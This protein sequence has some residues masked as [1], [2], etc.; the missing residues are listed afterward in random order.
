MS[1]PVGPSKV[2][3]RVRVDA[4]FL[5]S[6]GEFRIPTNVWLALTRLN[7]WIEPTLIAEWI[8]LMGRYLGRQGRTVREGTAQDALTWLDPAR[9][10]AE[11]RKIAAG[12]ISAG[13]KIYCIWT[14]R[15]LKEG[16]FDI[17]HCLPFVCWP[18]SDLWNLMPTTMRVNRHD[19]ADRLV[20]AGLF[21]KAH[22]RIL[23]WWNRAYLKRHDGIQIRFKQEARASLPITATSGVDI[24][25]E[26]VFEGLLAKRLMLKASQGLVEW[27]GPATRR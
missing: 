5:W 17:D 16:E 20:S 25:I 3:E 22:D 14:G 23:D 4:P 1:R 9:E 10:T 8:R 11:V 7:V 6:F 2:K 24:G 19:K 26:D 27:D 15:Q 21:D 18:N 12:L 13:E